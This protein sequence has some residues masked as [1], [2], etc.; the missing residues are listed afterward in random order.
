[1]VDASRQPVVLM[2]DF[3]LPPDDAGMAALYRSTRAT[4][5][6]G[7]D[8]VDQVRGRCRCGRATHSGG[9][10]LDYVFVSARDF[11]LR[12]VSVVGAA[13]SDHEVLRGV[14]AAR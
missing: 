9:S 14:V 2:G 7:L 3:N 8:E 6:A 13:F 4:R 12:G 10:K 5:R 1:M 11:A